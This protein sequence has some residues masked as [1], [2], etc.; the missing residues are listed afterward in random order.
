MVL[1][2]TYTFDDYAEAN[3]AHVGAGKS[4][5][6]ARAGWIGWVLFV[7]LAILLFTL[8]RS[9]GGPTSGG[10]AAPAVPLPP[11]VPPRG[12]VAN[13]FLPLVPWLLIFLAIWFFVFRLLRAVNKPRQSFLFD[14]GS[15]RPDPALGPAAGAAARSA[16]AWVFIITTVIASLV[17]MVANS[18]SSDTD[19]TVGR[20]ALASVT[21]T[22]LPWFLLFIA[23]KTLLRRGGVGVR[24]MWTG[25]PHLHRPKRIEIAE[26]G[27][28][29]SDGVSRLEEL[30]PAFSHARETKNLFLLYVSDYSFHM[31]PKRA[32]ATTADTDAFREMVRR[33]VVERPGPAFPVLPASPAHR[34]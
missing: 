31:V 11:T 23:F 3:A 26:P 16:G 5:R 12:S 6:R 18:V 7:G 33:M 19:N 8:L 13:V 27:V 20:S 25:Q 4:P 2:V 29:V 9:A 21:L 30:W 32:F 24:R 28:V 10:P 34:G 1:D 15:G 14:P 22:V 17:L